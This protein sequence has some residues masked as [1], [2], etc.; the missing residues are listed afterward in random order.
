MAP[1]MKTGVAAGTTAMPPGGMAFAR[2]LLRAANS[3]AVTPGHSCPSERSCQHTLLLKMQA[4]LCMRQ[5]TLLQVGNSCQ[6]T[7]TSS[8]QAYHSCREISEIL[9]FLRAHMRV[10][11]M[12]WLACYNASKSPQSLCQSAYSSRTCHGAVTTSNVYESPLCARNADDCIP[13]LDFSSSPNA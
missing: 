8:R 5:T 1:V 12:Y 4:E 6:G 2:R 13:L 9:G 7:Y 10:G 3:A 11:L